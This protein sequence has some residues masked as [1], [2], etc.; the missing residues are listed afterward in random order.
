[1]RV[2]IY[3]TDHK[4]ST[5]GTEQKKSS[6]CRNGTERKKLFSSK[7]SSQFRTTIHQW[8]PVKWMVLDF[9]GSEWHRWQC[10]KTLHFRILTII[11]KTYSL[12]PCQAITTPRLLIAGKVSTNALQWTNTIAYIKNP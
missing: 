9:A 10:N 6:M 8:G 12:C 2:N 4:L 5:N 1:M 11:V 3:E 7:F